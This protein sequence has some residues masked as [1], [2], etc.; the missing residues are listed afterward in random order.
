MSIC[1]AIFDRHRGEIGFAS[2]P[3]LTEFHFTLPLAAAVAKL[4][5]TGRPTSTTLVFEG[6]SGKADEL[7]A[8]VN[9]I[10][11]VADVAA[12]VGA[13]RD[14]LAAG[15]Y[16][17]LTLD[18]GAADPPTLALVDELRADGRPW[19]LPV[20]LISTG[21]RSGLSEGAVAWP[22][23]PAN[24]PL[25]TILHVEDDDD[26]ATVVANLLE[27]K[28]TVVHARRLG[29]AVEAVRRRAFD[30]VIHDI[31]LPDGSGLEL[32]PDLR[33]LQ[34]VPPVMLFAAQEVDAAT[35][36]QLAAAL[37]KSRTDNE[38]F[39]KR[40]L[41]LVGPAEGSRAEAGSA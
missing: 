7:C 41:D 17:A 26:L 29:E 25:P 10:G 12:S 11:L 37:V 3:G 20:I 16:A 38:Q 5:P 39:V 9:R 34:T 32:L 13:A 31:G 8:I 2:R 27:G 18:L 23:R 33:G 14:K 21:A 6:D 15:S 24:V 4:A 28:A 36:T 30:L 22:G 19:D 35:G 40:V 1:K